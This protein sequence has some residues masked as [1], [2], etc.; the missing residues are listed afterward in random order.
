[1]GDNKFATIFIFFVGVGAKK[2]IVVVV[3]FSSV[4]LQRRQWLVKP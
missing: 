1:M 2:V 3:F 4:L